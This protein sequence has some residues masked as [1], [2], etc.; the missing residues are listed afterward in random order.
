MRGVDV[1]F[2]GSTVPCRQGLRRP[3]DKL[4]DGRKR[5]VMPGS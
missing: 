2:D 3:G 5:M 4:V 1:V